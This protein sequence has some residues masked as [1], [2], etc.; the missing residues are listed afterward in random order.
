MTGLSR[1]CGR[2]HSMS[3]VGAKK[4]PCTWLNKSTH[5]YETN[6]QYWYFS[7]SKLLDE[8]TLILKSAFWDSGAGISIEPG[9]LN[10][11]QLCESHPS[12]SSLHLV[13]IIPVQPIRFIAVICILVVVEDDSMEMHWTWNYTICRCYVMHLGDHRFSGSWRTWHNV[14][15]IKEGSI[16]FI[17]LAGLALSI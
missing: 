8:H 6:K 4:R 2:F 13:R 12:W 1:I 17:V 16:I 14:N 11:W 7:N 3:L 5:K 10:P 15:A 9:V